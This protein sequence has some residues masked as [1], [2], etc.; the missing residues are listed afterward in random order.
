L[1]KIPDRTSHDHLNSF[2]MCSGYSGY[3]GY[4]GYSG[5]SGC[6]K[7]ASVRNYIESDDQFVTCESGGVGGVSIMTIIG[8][9]RTP[10]KKLQEIAGCICP[11]SNLPTAQ[12]CFAS[13][14]II[15][16]IFH[17]GNILI[18]NIAYIVAIWGFY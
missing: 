5:Y 15:E 14:N 18:K 17:K 7:Y 13:A 10:I 6:L 3:L 2:E 11:I 9:M 16:G 1:L 4:S 12:R 8:L